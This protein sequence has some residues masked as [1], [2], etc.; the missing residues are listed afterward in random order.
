[1]GIEIIIM[2]KLKEIGLLNVNKW[3]C[4]LIDWNKHHEYWKSKFEYCRRKQSRRWKDKYGWIK[5]W[6]IKYSGI[7]I[8]WWGGKI[9]S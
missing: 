8:R 7:I 5:K 3:R 9:K 4:N 2:W 1:M 6:S